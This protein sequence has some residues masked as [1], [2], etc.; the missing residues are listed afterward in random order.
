MKKEH[1]V[2]IIK[3]NE[4]P[5]ILQFRQTNQ[6]EDKEYQS[7][8]PRAESDR[9]VFLSREQHKNLSTKERRSVLDSHLCFL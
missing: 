6:L 2:V 8:G 7:I 3:K 5:K 9:L 1:T 4:T